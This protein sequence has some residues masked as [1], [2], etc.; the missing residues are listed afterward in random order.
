M[1]EKKETK[2]WNLVRNGTNKYDVHWTRIEN[3]VDS[4]TPDTWGVYKGIYFPVELK[5]EVEGWVYMRPAQVIWMRRHLIAGGVPWILFKDKN[6]IIVLIKVTEFFLNALVIKTV[7]NKEYLAFSVD[8]FSTK[9]FKKNYNYEE[10][11]N[12]LI[13]KEE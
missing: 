11:L 1:A 13:G 8:C 6:D 4:G 7:Y 3:L 10:I 2:L 9:E 5:M 12:T